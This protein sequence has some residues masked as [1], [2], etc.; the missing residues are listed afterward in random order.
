MKVLHRIVAQKTEERD[1]DIFDS[2]RTLEID[3]LSQK[4]K[5]DE[6][7]TA[8]KRQRA[9]ADVLKLLSW[10]AGTVSSCCFLWY[11]VSFAHS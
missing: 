2:I 11:G 9:G 4:V 10:S 5:K 8:S 3:A 7:V 1:R 6:G